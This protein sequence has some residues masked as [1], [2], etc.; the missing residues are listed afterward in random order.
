MCLDPDLVHVPS[1]SASA[2]RGA[3]SRSPA[4]STMSLDTAKDLSISDL[5]RLLGE[6]LDVECA[7]LRETPLSPALPAFSLKSE[8]STL[9]LINP[10]REPSDQN[11]I[12]I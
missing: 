7:R 12:L 3:E 1:L 6:K 4:T 8:A 2:V 5:L 10:F 11:T 9:R